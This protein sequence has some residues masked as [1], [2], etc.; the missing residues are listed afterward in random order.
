MKVAITTLGCKVNSYESDALLELFHAKGYESVPFQEVA[1]VYVVN[2]CMVTNTAE[3][4]SKKILHRP[5]KIAPNATVVV[6]GC[7]SQKSA[8]EMLQI[9]GV[10]IVVG[11]K[12]RE[13]IPAYLDNYFET[14]LIQNYVSDYDG[15]EL[16]DTLQLNH[17]ETHTRAFLKIEDGCDNFCSYCIIPYTR[18]PVRS[19]PQAKVMAE[20]QHLV[21]HGHREIILT[22][23]HT[24]A[25]GK[26]LDGENL[27]TL[28]QELETIENLKRIRISSIEITELDDAIIEWI[29]HSNKVVH[30]LH[31]PLQGGTNAIL[32]AMN[33]KYTVQEYQ[34]KIAYLREKIPHL[35]ITTDII[36]GFP[37]ETDEEHIQTLLLVG[38]LAFSEIHV[39]PYSNRT[40]SASS[41]MKNQIS[42]DVKKA[43]VRNLIR[44]NNRL[45]QTFL[46]KEKPFVQKV[47]VET[48]R[49]G[50][51]EGHT[52]NY[53]R[54]KFPG[55][56][57]TI[58]QILSV[59]ITEATY[60]LSQ[61]I[62]VLP[63]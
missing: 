40:G 58:G 47:L 23:I 57:S 28:L 8:E 4:K 27:L 55:N 11:T 63:Q 50:W 18:G 43:R 52:D 62:E 45:A 24:G 44:L 17:S 54:V 26:D 22:G 48:C 42:D 39:F 30:H 37:D 14:G 29:A 61:G 59:Q 36:A 12:N 56:A 51:A 10:K 53:L 41:T 2:T 15:S 46:E 38:T 60:P 19:K 49:D 6:M 31:I 35:A 16:H 32:H 20:A 21:E 13:Q 34:E 9:P 3:S 1:D 33:R 5:L 7:L 25:Y